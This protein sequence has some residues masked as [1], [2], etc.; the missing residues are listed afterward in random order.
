[1]IQRKIQ[2]QLKTNLFFCIVF[3]LIDNL[4]I[5]I[6]LIVNYKLTITWDEIFSLGKSLE[7]YR[8]VLLVRTIFI[9]PVYLFS[10]FYKSKELNQ[11][12]LLIR[13]SLGILFS[14]SIVFFLF[15]PREQQHFVKS[16]SF[17][18]LTSCLSWTLFYLTT[19]VMKFK[20]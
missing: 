6:Y 17:F 2:K 11:N 16:F 3:F 10:F 9:L 14:M 13:M 4:I 20:Y 1:M 19:K 8:D 18:L 7:L 15:A 5:S 12:S